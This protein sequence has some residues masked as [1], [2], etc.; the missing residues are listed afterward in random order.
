MSDDLKRIEEYTAAFEKAAVAIGFLLLLLVLWVR[1]PHFQMNPAAGAGFSGV[2]GFNVGH[3]VVFGP[4]A[5]FLSLCLYLGMLGRR[6][7]LR[8]LFLADVQAGAYE[9]DKLSSGDLLVL[10]KYHRPTALWSIASLADQLI[11]TLWFFVLPLAA[12]AIFIRRYLDFVP[13]PDV[14]PS[15]ETSAWSLLTRLNLHF[16]SGSLWEIRP[17]LHDHYLDANSVVSGQMPY[18]YSPLQ[19]WFYV[20]LF[21]ASLVLAGRSWAL[22]FRAAKPSAGAVPGDAKQDPPATDNEEKALNSHDMP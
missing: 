10:N 21:V 11:R 13:A 17:A 2:V 5:V 19:S 14:V 7:Q 15:A 18:I 16:F 8:E 9:D 4:I 20:V 1:A 22:Y 3:A 12:S 6:E